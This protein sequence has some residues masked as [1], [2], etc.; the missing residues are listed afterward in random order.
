MLVM[1]FTVFIIIVS[2]DQ[3]I[4]Y[5][6]SNSYKYGKGRERGEGT[7]IETSG[8]QKIAG[9]GITCSMTNNKP[10]GNFCVG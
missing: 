1:A 7:V 2:C 9:K 8:Q 4:L 3:K 10:Y 6:S 5:T